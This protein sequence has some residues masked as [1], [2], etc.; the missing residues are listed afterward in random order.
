MITPDELKA[1]LKKHRWSMG[2]SKSG[3][4]QVYAAK[5]RRGKRLATCYIGTSNTLNVL[6]ESDVV[7]K[8]NRK[9]APKSLVPSSQTNDQAH[10]V[11]G[12]PEMGYMSVLPIITG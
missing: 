6:T 10:T 11:Q 7:E 3:K 4:Q 8:I 5:Q 12:Y 2:V 1:L 9:A